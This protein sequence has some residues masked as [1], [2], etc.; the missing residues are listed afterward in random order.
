LIIT[1][2]SADL[3]MIHT[4]SM[5]PMMMSPGLIRTPS[6]AIGTRKSITFPLGP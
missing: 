4:P 6:I 2:F 1:S 5:S 3:G